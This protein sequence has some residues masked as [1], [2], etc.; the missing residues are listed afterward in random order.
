MQECKNWILLHKVKCKPVLL[1]LS[2][3][4]N[5]EKP[6]MSLSGTGWRDRGYGLCKHVYSILIQYSHKKGGRGGELT[7][8]KVRKPIDYKVG[9]KYQHD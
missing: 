5:L 4:G 7:R 3:V 2:L 9:R 6:L 1:R 8:E